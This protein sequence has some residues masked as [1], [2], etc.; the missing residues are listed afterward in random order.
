MSDAP[1][2]LA[3]DERSRGRPAG[4]VDVAA[5]G[6]TAA[7]CQRH[8]VLLLDLDGVVYRG[9]NAIR[10]AVACVLAAGERGART[11]FVT[12]NAARLPSEV[13]SHLRGL[14]LPARDDDVVTSAQAGAA[15]L[16]DRVGPGAEVLAVGGPGVAW[17][18]R[19]AGLVPVRG[20]DAGPQGA[21]DG[22]VAAVMVGYG[23]D[24]SWR[25]L[26]AASY[27]ITAGAAFVATN[28][29]LTIPTEGG[30]APGNGAMVA[31]IV[32]ATGV[33]PEV[34]GK[35]FSPLLQ[36]AIG[37][38]GATQPLVV[39]DRLDTDI[40]AAHRMRLPGLLVLTGVTAV[41]DLL[42]APPQ[43]RPTYVAADLRGLLAPGC[44][45]VPAARARVGQ[46]GGLRVGDRD[47]ADLLSRLRA[48]AA[49]CWA[50]ADSGRPAELPDAVVASLS[51]DVDAALAG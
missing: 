3:G 46:D 17:A 43:R 22:P 1:G 12:N 11:A 20:S 51:A 23:P 42:R 45:L 26:A 19:V 33:A 27:A 6:R 28:T 13:A 24:V 5:D 31:A 37:Q 35:P 2:R 38:T 40:E 4:P 9:P 32:T 18:L 15:L 30:V 14:G 44:T 49:A 7:L 25:D 8:D 47:P 48:A 34:A 39:G 29:D 41:A 21:A 36:R 10:H 16:R 50:A